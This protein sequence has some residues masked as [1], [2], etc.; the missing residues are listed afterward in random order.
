MSSQVVRMATNQHG[1]HVVNLCLKRFSF[2]D[3]D[4]II[5]EISEA[6]VAVSNHVQGC[7]V[8]QNCLQCSSNEQREMLAWRIIECSK[9][10]VE[11]KYGNYVV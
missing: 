8:I 9:D 10:L 4:F 2:K 6:C 11:N 7:M 1:N 3:K 5:S